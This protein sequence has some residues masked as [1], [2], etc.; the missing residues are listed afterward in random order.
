MATIIQNN[1]LIVRSDK[2][3]KEYILY[4]TQVSMRC[5]G[6]RIKQ[7]IHFF[8]TPDYIAKRKDANKY[9]PIPLPSARKIEENAIG[10][11]YL[12]IGEWKPLNI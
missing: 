6:G 3:H 5:Y 4:E 1:P 10:S 9:R 7:K 12:T 2:N 11:P 8:S